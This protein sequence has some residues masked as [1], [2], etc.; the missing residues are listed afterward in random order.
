MK[1]LNSCDFTQV[2][3]VHIQTPEQQQESE[4]AML[5]SI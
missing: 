3:Y 1:Q 5:C 2:R 4:L